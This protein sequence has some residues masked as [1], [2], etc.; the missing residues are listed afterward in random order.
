RKEAVTGSVASV[1]GDQMREVPSGNIS[2]AL[3][4][5]V[6]GVEMS[7]NSSKPGSSMQ[8]RIRGTRSL[9]A[10]N[11]PLV[12][13]DGIPFAGSIGDINPNDIQSIDILKDASSSAIYGSRG[14]NGVILITTK[15]GAAGQKATFSYHGY[16]GITTL[17]SDFPMMNGEEFVKLRAT[18]GQYQNTL[19]ESDDINT[20]W[21]DLVFETG[22]LTSHD[23]GVT[24][25]TEKGSYNFGLG[26]YKDDGVVPLQEY[27]RISMRASFD[28]QIGS[29]FRVGLTT[30]NNYSITDGSNVPA[31]G[32][33]LARS[34]IANPYNPDGSLKETLLEQT[35]GAQWVPTND[36]FYELGDKYINQNRAFSSYNSMFG[37]L[38][39]PFIDGLK[40][41]INVG[42]NYRQSN[43]GS[44]TGEG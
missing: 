9:N 41:R 33:A 14:A 4:G 28:Q 25:G 8:I 2:R 44:Y 38:K 12:V 10:D 22:M 16:S 30:N 20:E 35:S 19:D 39:I 31:V 7:Q 34:P 6:A 1:S 27:E 11:D 21:Q 23:I 13:L 32:M 3:Q 36:R 15:K 24:G 42:L 26:Y 17:F 40:Y 43:D 37:E 29:L 18:A 5:R